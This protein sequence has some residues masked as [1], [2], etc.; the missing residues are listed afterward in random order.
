MATNF[1]LFL[2]S[3]ILACVALSLWSTSF[4]SGQWN[5]MGAMMAQAFGAGEAMSDISEASMQIGQFLSMISVGIIVVTLVACLLVYFIACQT[6]VY[7]AA[8]REA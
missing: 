6:I 7:K 5:R 3:P 4:V 1:A 8:R 2:I